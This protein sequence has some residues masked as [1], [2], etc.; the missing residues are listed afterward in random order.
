MSLEPICK[1]L[2]VRK[3]TKTAR[4]L[5]EAFH[6][7]AFHYEEYDDLAKSAFKIKQYDLAVKYGEDALTNALSNEK[8]WNAR[9]N[10][11]NVYNHANYPEKA[12]RL[13]RAQE[14]VI[15][16]DIDTQL[17]KSFALFLSGD[18]KGA[19]AI[20]REQL[21]NSE[22][23]EDTRTKIMFNLGTYE[24]YNG[25]FLYG[26]ELFQLEGQKLD[27]W[28]KT[29]L[30]GEFWFGKPADQCISK[31]LVVF[32]EAGIGDEFINIRFLNVLKARGFN[33]IWFTARKDLNSIYIRSGFKVINNVKDRPE[34]SMW[35][36]SMTLPLY[37]EMKPEELWTGPYL[38]ADPKYVK[39]YS[40][41]REDDLLHVGL[42]WQGNP[43]YDQ[44]LHRSIPF[45]TLLDTVCQ[46]ASIVVSLQKDNGLDEAIAAFDYGWID[47]MSNAMQTYEDTLGIIANLDVVITSCT[48]VAHASAAMGKRTIILVPLSAYYV[49]SHPT[50]QSP[51]YGD[52]VTIIRQTKPREWDDVIEK[53]NG[54]LK[55]L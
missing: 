3:E 40:S 50:E 4:L 13:I 23:S 34:S 52:H 5:L 18:R 47:D 11:I 53:L 25:N 48:S 35:T 49:W 17:E 46:H 27:Y 44:D 12:L 24:L 9:A 37:L 7:S 55:C 43:E 8:M 51:W 33:P 14:A 26:L 42:R 15:P 38:S 28:Q 36:Y 20:L 31:D 32:A 6:R 39:K 22:I 41:L 1:A 29:K 16:S 54:Y 2:N 10:L 21:L 30:D 19:E 45:T